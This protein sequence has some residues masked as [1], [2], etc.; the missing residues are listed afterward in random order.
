PSHARQSAERAARI[1]RAKIPLKSTPP[2]ALPAASPAAPGATPHGE[3]AAA[4]NGSWGQRTAPPT[5]LPR[6]SIV[7]VAVLGG[8]LALAAASPFVFRSGPGDTTAPQASPSPS[9]P[10]QAPSSAP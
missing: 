8:V 1:L 4:T 2:P 3:Q 7:F 10:D 5:K 9:P 6:L